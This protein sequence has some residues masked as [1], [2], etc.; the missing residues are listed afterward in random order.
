LVSYLIDS[1][2]D[3]IEIAMKLLV[4]NSPQSLATILSQ[5]LFN[6]YRHN[7]C[8]SRLTHSSFSLVS[9]ATS[10]PRAAVAVTVLSQ[11]EPDVSHYLL[12]QRKNPPDA[13]KWSFP[14]GKI[15][16]GERTIDAAQRELTEETNLMKS[17][18][19]WYSDPFITTDAIFKD[20]DDYDEYS[21]HYLIAHCFA[22]IKTKGMRSHPVV[23][24]SDDA[25]DAKWWTVDEIESKLSLNDDV[26]DGVLEV[27]FRAQE[28]YENKLVPVNGV[29]S[30]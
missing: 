16:L 4:F 19:L 13:G 7:G 25:L 15:E 27:I 8:K 10:F 29:W 28:L 2:V 12:I 3:C 21:F 1:L 5:R 20:V 17:D 9:T 14:G 26:S 24:A 22:Q 23:R 18:C 6:S 11:R 30:S